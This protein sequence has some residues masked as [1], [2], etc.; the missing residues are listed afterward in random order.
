MDFWMLVMAE[1][2]ARGDLVP[3]RTHRPPSLAGLSGVLKR[4]STNAPCQRPTVAGAVQ[5]THV[6]AVA[7]LHVPLADALPA[8]SRG[9]RRVADGPECQSARVPRGL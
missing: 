6:P 4:A 8:G 9:R 3:D 5:S 7:G 2:Q 1:A